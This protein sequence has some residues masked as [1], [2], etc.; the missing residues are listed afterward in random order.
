SM[1]DTGDER[2]DVARDR[3][4]QT[5]GAGRAVITSGPPVRR[6]G[7]LPYLALS[8]GVVAVVIGQI[9]SNM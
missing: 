8:A 5:A 9:L 6:A 7:M 4:T 3:D 2:G 1:Y